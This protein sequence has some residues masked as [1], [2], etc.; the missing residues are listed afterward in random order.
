MYDEKSL[1]ALIEAQ[2]FKQ[3]TVLKSG[4]TMIKDPGNLDLHERSWESLYLEAVK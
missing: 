1:S 4:E 3:V 2:G